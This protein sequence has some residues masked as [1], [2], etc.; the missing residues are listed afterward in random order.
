MGK[1]SSLIRAAG[2]EKRFCSAVILAAGQGKRFSDD[3]AKQYVEIAGE[4]ILVRSAKAFEASEEVDEIVVV[5]R[6]TDVIGCRNILK[7]AG[8]TK[9]T[10]VIGG[11]ETR[12]ASA[13]RGFDAVNPAA[14]Y[15]A[16]HDAA[17]CLVTPEMIEAVFEGAYVTGAAAA[18]SRNP[19][20][21]KRTDGTDLV[22]ET[23]D[24]E[25]TWLVQTPQIFK[26]EIYRAA[27]YLAQRDSVT[28]T[29][30]CA[31]CE[32]LG[33]PVRLVD[34]GPTNI[35]ITYP[36]DIVMAEAILRAREAG[37]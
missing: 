29:D 19:D 28:A 8:I 22:K 2:H 36:A 6:E 25:N 31:L 11:G 26:A 15:V 21:I 12:Q 32:R 20:T 35:K 9:V 17:R 1:L 27:S 5:T 24:R 18:A 37:K 30:D 10:R 33:F 3:T 7:K 13:K 34:C 23:V 16:I 4:S 14:E